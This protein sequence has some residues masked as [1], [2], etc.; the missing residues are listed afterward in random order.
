MRYRTVTRSPF[1]QKPQ[2]GFPLAGVDVGKQGNR[3]GHGLF[4]LVL[5]TGDMMK[6]SQM[7]VK[8]RLA[9]SVTC[10]RADLY[11]LL[12]QS[13]RSVTIPDLEE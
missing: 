8:R 1:G 13:Y 6:V 4:R 7:I 10:V 11:G 2:F 9:M 12:D 3:F 5:T